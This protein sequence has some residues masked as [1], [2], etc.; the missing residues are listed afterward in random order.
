MEAFILMT[1]VPIPGKTKTRLM[2]ILTAEECAEIHRC[3]LKDLFNM[4][5]YIKNDIDIYLTY[6]P[7][8]S[9]D[10]MKD[11]VP[12]YI[13]CFPQNGHDLGEKM[14]N[15]FKH[16]FNKGYSKV[17]LMGSDI[18]D[19]H[20]EEIKDSFK[21]L[22]KS[23]IVIGPTFDGG[24]YFVGMK[25][26]YKELFTGNLKWGNKTV[27]EGTVD[28]AN[29]LGLKVDLLNKHRDID[30]KDD[31]ISFNK[32]INNREFKKGIYPEN[33]IKFLKNNWGDF[34]YVKRYIK[35]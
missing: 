24:Y 8:D 3:F 6:T 4:F 9:F 28:I 32:R 19:I 16:I 34:K 17:C 21:K 5:D 20:Y 35:G 33:T 13:E 25:R 1:R 22:E 23:D 11:I 10:L 27:L 29:S 26:I 15:A 2:E 12:D 30:T 18:P 7:E 31:L 14:L